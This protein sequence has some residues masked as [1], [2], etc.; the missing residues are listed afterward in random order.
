[1]RPR[2]PSSPWADGPRAP[3]AGFHRSVAD[4]LAQHHEMSFQPPQVG[5]AVLMMLKAAGDNRKFL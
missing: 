1:M 5:R 4:L 3:K 2:R